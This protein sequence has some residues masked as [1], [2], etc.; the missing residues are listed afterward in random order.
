MEAIAAQRERSSRSYFPPAMDSSKLKFY[1]LVLRKA[2]HDNNDDRGVDGNCGQI[3]GKEINR[4]PVSKKTAK[5]NK[6][7]APKSAKVKLSDLTPKKQPKGGARLIGTSDCG[8][9]G[10]YPR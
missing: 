3:N 4:M 2:F 10:C 5:R 6:R 7:N 8:A 9:G 1:K